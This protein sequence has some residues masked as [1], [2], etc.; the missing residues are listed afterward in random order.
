M[1]IRHSI[2]TVGLRYGLVSGGL[3]VVLFFVV[4]LF[5]ENP[6][7]VTKWFDY[8][9]IPGFVFFSVREFRLYYNGGAMQFWQGASVGFITYV[10]S[11]LLFA[12]VIGGYLAT[13]GEGWVTDYVADRTALVQKNQESFTQELGEATYRQVLDEVRATTP[14]DL[15]LDDF[16]R[17]LMVG[18]FVTLIIATV[19]RR[20]PAKEM[21]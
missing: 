9:L 11:A 16:Y 18:V 8:L 20:Q 1:N 13:A 12:L 14:L 6:L 21:S 4:M 7:I 2:I 17:K 15:V 3:A 5:D 19:Q 10:T